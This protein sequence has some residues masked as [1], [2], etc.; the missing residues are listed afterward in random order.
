MSVIDDIEQ[1]WS[2]DI[3]SV[4]APNRN[5]SNINDVDEIF[6]ISSEIYQVSFISIENGLLALARIQ[7]KASIFIKF[8]FS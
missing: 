7:T 2:K 6:D 5:A 4:L 3:C 8:L 1:G